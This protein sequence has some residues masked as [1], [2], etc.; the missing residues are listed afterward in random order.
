MAWTTPQTWSVLEQLTAAKMNE[1]LRDN[2]D[3]LKTA[4]DNTFTY[5]EDRT[6]SITTTS[7]TYVDIDCA[8]SSAAPSTTARALVLMYM[9]L[10]NSSAGQS[11]DIRIYETT[12]STTIEEQTYQSPGNY[13][14]LQTIARVFVPG[15]TNS[16]T[17]KVQVKTS[18]G[19]CYVSDCNLV[20]AYVY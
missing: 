9:L 16:M 15:S 19:T 13:Y 20:V 11:V 2:M 14:I 1:Q 3:Y 7:T 17:Y 18:S 10:K 12:T 4:V 8:V 5:N 6:G